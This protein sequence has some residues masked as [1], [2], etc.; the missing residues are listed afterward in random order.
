MRYP[1]GA[2]SVGDVFGSDASDLVST[3]PNPRFEW[4]QT[5]W[6]LYWSMIIY[7]HHPSTVMFYSQCKHTKEIS[8]SLT[9]FCVFTFGDSAKSPARVRGEMTWQATMSFSS[10][11]HALGKPSPRKCREEAMDI[12]RTGGRGQPRF[13]AF[14][15]F[16]LIS[17]KPKV[18]KLVFSFCWP[19]WC[20]TKKWKL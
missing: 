5:R 9:G 20:P 19:G 15:V 3:N 2:W 18:C 12:F 8:V 10:T 13:I 14:G 11:P 17:Q 6:S 7:I 4:N 1:V 16:F